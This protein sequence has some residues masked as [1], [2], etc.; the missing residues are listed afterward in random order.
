MHIASIAFYYGPEVA[1]SCYSEVWFNELGGLRVQGP[2]SAAKFVEEVLQELWK[3]QMIAFVTYHFH[4]ASNKGSRS[5]G[6]SSGQG[7]LQLLEDRRE[8]FRRWTQVDY[9]FLWEC[10]SRKRPCWLISG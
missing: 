6:L 5:Q 7:A 9:P 2:S 10:V 3:P 8:Q 4:R 1:A